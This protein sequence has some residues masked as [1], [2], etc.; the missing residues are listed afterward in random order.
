MSGA[1]CSPA[2][3]A[4]LYNMSS[5]NNE[6]TTTMIPNDYDLWLER[7]KAGNAGMTVE[8]LLNILR[9][10][11]RDIVVRIHVELPDGTTEARHISGTVSDWPY[12][13]L[14]T[15]DPV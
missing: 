15:S 13:T 9:E 2:L 4:M 11:D 10:Y 14:H 8:N 3:P 7:Q 1:W 6:E 5:T 12:L